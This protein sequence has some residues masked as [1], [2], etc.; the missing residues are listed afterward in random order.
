MTTIQEFTDADFDVE[1]F[2]DFG[3]FDFTDSGVI[4]SEQGV[5]KISVFNNM[6]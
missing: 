3:D 2:D 5:G 1:F 6:I 4:E